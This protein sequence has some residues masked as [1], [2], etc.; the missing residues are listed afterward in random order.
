MT[1]FFFFFFFS[2]LAQ[3]SILRKY[4]AC[5]YNLLT[6]TMMIQYDKKYLTPAPFE[7]RP[8][9]NLLHFQSLYQLFLTHICTLILYCFMSVLLSNLLPLSLSFSIYHSI[10]N[11]F[12]ITQVLPL[13]FVSF[14]WCPSIS[15]FPIPI[16]N[17]WYCFFLITSYTCFPTQ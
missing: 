4:V 14:I 11:S 7:M 13:C 9:L 10:S 12:I 2:C 1:D 15:F 16:H 5:A 3:S 8:Y 17:T 6:W